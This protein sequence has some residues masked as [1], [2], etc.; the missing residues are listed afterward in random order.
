MIFS[1]APTQPA[2]N[3]YSTTFRLGDDRLIEV[4]SGPFDQK[5]VSIWDTQG[6]RLVDKVELIG[7]DDQPIAYTPW[8]LRDDGNGAFSIFVQGSTSSG[9]QAD[10][11]L[12]SYDAQGVQTRST[13]YERLDFDKLRGDAAIDVGDGKVLAVVN[14]GNRVVSRL[15]DADGVIVNR[16]LWNATETGA[17]SARGDNLNFTLARAGDTVFVFYVND[18]AHASNGGLFLTRLT[19]EGELLQ[20]ADPEEQQH[21]QNLAFPRGPARGMLEAATLSNGKIALVY[22]ADRQHEDDGTPEVEDTG[23]DIYLRIYNPDGS[24][25][26]GETRI[27]EYFLEHQED[28]RLFPLEN[29]GFVVTYQNIAPE[30]PWWNPTQELPPFE[31]P[32][33]TVVLRVFDAEGQP[34]SDSEAPLDAYNWGENSQIFPD[35]SGYI[36]GPSGVFQLETNLPDPPRALMGTDDA[37]LLEGGNGADTLNGLAGD[38]TLRGGDGTDTLIGGEGD[39]VIEGGATEAD[40]RDVVYGGDGDDSIDGGYGNDELRG[41]AGNDTVSGGFGTDT[42]IG[43]DGDDVLTGQAWSDLLYGGAGNDFVNGGFGYDRVNGGEGAD[44]F[45]HLGV[46]DHGADWIQDYDAA[47]GD[48]LVFGGTGASADDFLVQV[49]ETANAGVA[50][51]QEAFITHIPTGNLLWALV[52]GDA[53]DAINLRI[54]AEIHDLL[55]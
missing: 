23:A 26:R 33:N 14:V 50:G 36:I 40:L 32:E 30:A 48:V 17:G 51:V 47:E 54:G 10:L 21:I 35:G 22:N 20:P 6:N 16:T 31:G 44:R 4:T 53:Q 5:Q 29:G 41:D 11:R 9:T 1:I 34:M 2:I 15:Y 39:D 28:V 49:T 25:H 55:L 13:T 45:F 8:H 46:A 52:D 7:P 27:N 19:L 37:D 24:E 12:V 3:N 43:A 42:V 38:D 18:D